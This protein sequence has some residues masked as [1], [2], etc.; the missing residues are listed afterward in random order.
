MLTDDERAIAQ[1]DFDAYVIE[2][3]AD[4]A[5]RPP[6]TRDEFSRFAGPHVRAGYHAEADEAARIYFREK[7]RE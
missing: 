6:M 4:A 5:K 1:A 7:H 2:I 3:L